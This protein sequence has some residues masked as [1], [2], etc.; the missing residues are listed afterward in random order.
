[1]QKHSLTPILRDLNQTAKAIADRLLEL[2]SQDKPKAR[3]QRISDSL[4]VFLTMMLKLLTILTIL[5]LILGVVLHQYSSRSDVI[6]EDFKVPPELEQKGYKSDVIATRLADRMNA[7]SS[8]T[9]SSV[10]TNTGASATT[11][12]AGGK[13]TITAKNFIGL[14]T[15]KLTSAEPPL[16]I[17]VPQTHATVGSLF[18][19]LF[20]FFGVKP[21]RIDG[22]ITGQNGKLVL[23]IRITDGDTK[24]V[25]GVVTDES[26]NPEALLSKGAEAIYKDIKPVVLAWYFYGSRPTKSE[27]AK[28]LIQDCI[29]QNKDAALANV[30]WAVILQNE[31][32]YDGALTKIKDAEQLK[33][34]NTIHEIVVS[35]QARYLEARGEFDAA[36][37]MYEQALREPH[38]VLTLMNY[39]ALLANRGYLVEASKWYR[40]ALCIDKDSDIA[41]IGMGLVLEGQA[42]YDEAISEYR[43]AIE[44]NP[45]S[46]TAYNNLASALVNKKD[47]QLATQVAHKAVEL[48]PDSAD[49][50]N[51]LGY[52]LYSENRFDEAIKEYERA[53]AISPR[54]IAAYVNWADALLN[55]GK[56]NEA[57]AKTKKALEIDSTS[58]LAHTEMA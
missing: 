17:E 46:A 38:S 54:F 11:N 36:K 31:A 14:P 57:E 6:L 2:K 3:V 5:I 48:E 4:S 53:V 56:Y 32:D 19:Y 9:A 55:Q 23:T 43:K 50:H 24:R 30:L 8:K 12:V 15:F 37:E 27:E 52:V 18:R 26:G 20:E 1:M 10:G 7:I 39:G 51:T 22:D 16:D 13:G 41:H 40:S 47:Y 28:A 34:E 25:L 21:S 44:L 35:W 29:Y 42:Y 58:V 45:G 33:P 49:T